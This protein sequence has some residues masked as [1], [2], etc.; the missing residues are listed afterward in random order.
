[1]VWK[2]QLSTEG[3]SRENTMPSISSPTQSA[4]DYTLGC[5]RDVDALT[6]CGRYGI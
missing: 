4:S 1:M 2:H 5:A 3:Y 6:P